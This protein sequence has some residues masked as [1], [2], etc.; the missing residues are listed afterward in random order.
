MNVPHVHKS[1]PSVNPSTRERAVAFVVARLSSSRLPRKQFRLIGDRS[2][3]QWIVDHLRACKELDE[4]VIAT[5]AEKENEPLR[6]FARDQGVSC[7]WY[8]GEVDHVTTRLRRAAEEFKADICVLVSGD[9]PL[10]HAPSI[11]YLIRDARQHP[12]AD[13]IEVKEDDE[14]NLPALEGIGIARSRAWQRADDLSDRPELKEHHF[15]IIGRRPDLFKTHLCR[16]SKDLYNPHQHRLSVDTWA[17]LEF[18]NAIYDSLSA[19]NTSF[20]LPD[21]LNLLKKNPSLLEINRHVHQMGVCEERR[22][23]LMIA[24]A[25]NGYGYGHVMRSRELALQITE[26]LGWAVTFAVDDEKAR[27]MLKEAGIRTIKKAQSPKLKAQSIAEKGVSSAFKL[28]ELPDSFDLIILDIYYRRT[29]APG[30]RQGFPRN[31]KVVVLDHQGN[32]TKEADLVVIPGV[33][34]D[35]PIRTRKERHPRAIAGKQYVILRRQIRKLQGMHVEKEIVL[36]AYLYSPEQK[37]A[38]RNLASKNGFKVHVVE[39]FDS[40]F[41]GLLARSSM[42]LSGFGYSFYEALALGAYPITL[43]LSEAHK[44]DA[45]KFYDRLGIPSGVL[46]S[47]KEIEHAANDLAQQ[48][49]KFENLKIEDGTPRIVEE[50]ASLLRKEEI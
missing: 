27:Q 47:V 50:I 11:D 7:F 18:M 29:L 25:G 16:L 24:D 5:V 1:R 40:D 15:P 9:C 37:E 8:E 43:P 34:Y 38:V 23:V 42:F 13:V 35:D 44:T 6:D 49:K 10:I 48:E 19:T 21:V 32:W 17:D 39:D 2:M 36:L 45:K 31:C 26:R 12:D 46:E 14:G 28:P 30:W 22:K 4:I 41:P 3:L 33:T 20:Y